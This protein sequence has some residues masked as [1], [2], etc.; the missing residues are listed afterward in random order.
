MLTRKLCDQ[1]AYG[2][3]KELPYP[4]RKTNFYELFRHLKSHQEFFVT[5]DNTPANKTL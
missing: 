1:Q 3:K 5:F 2:T 4:G